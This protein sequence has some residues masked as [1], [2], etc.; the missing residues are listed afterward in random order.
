V[1]EEKQ[2]MDTLTPERIALNVEEA[3]RV[4]G[5]SRAALYPRVMSGEVPSFKV[6][7]RRLVLV[8]A[9][10]AWADGLADGGAA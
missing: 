6:G 5:L 10:R 4:L 2:G 3:A 8:S 7:T 1:D 9:L